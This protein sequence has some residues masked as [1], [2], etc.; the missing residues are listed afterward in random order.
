M[1]AG[2]RDVVVRL[3]ALALALALAGCTPMVE[4][5]PPIQHMRI[6]PAGGRPL[7]TLVALPASCGA[8]TYAP[9]DT[10]D[11]SSP[12]FELPAECSAAALA[13]V[14]VAIRSTLALGGYDVV[15]S[16]RIN[17]VTAERHEQEQRS[18]WS[19][20]R[21]IDQRGARFEDATP[22]EQARVLGELH[23]DGVVTIRVWIGA[24]VGFAGRRAVVVQVRL[25]A[26]DGALAWARR[27][28]IEVAGVL[29]RDPVAMERAARCAIE[30]T[31]TP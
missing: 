8:L 6:G 1:R 18:A 3:V 15:D 25:L 22:I 24:Q 23:A 7:R 4:P 17:L 26:R 16:E 20:T 12:G 14:D 21:T 27:C 28:E 31:A 2:E 29:A 11:P 30:G 13:A 9:V 19:A 5:Q 10:R